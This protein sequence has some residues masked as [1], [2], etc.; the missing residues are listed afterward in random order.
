[1]DRFMAIM[2]ISR[3]SAE[4]RKTRRRGGVHPVTENSATVDAWESDRKVGANMRI[5]SQNRPDPS[6]LDGGP[7]KTQC[8]FHASARS[9]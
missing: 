5:P 4:R 2:D 1:M 7:L 6:V 8:F 3:Q 9:R